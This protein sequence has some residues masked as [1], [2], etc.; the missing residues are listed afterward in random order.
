MS[1]IDS[2]TAPSSPYSS[3]ELTAV[4]ARRDDLRS[5]FDSATQVVLAA[6]PIRKLS[7]AAQE[8]FLLAHADM[9][10]AQ[11]LFQSSD[12][13]FNRLQYASGMLVV[14]TG[15][16]FGVAEALVIPACIRDIANKLDVVETL[17]DRLEASIAALSAAPEGTGNI[18]HN[19]CTCSHCLGCTCKRYVPG[20]KLAADDPVIIA[21]SA[22]RDL[23]SAGK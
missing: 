12:V 15:N 17:I 6:V 18:D 11:T 1:K 9:S 3:P 7:L 13:T 21:F 23:P 4:L 2:S 20:E 16:R 14:G 8:A 5:R 22:R 19:G 10:F